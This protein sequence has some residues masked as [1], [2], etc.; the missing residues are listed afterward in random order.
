MNKEQLQQSIDQITEAI[1]LINTCGG[2][3]YLKAHQTTQ[4][5]V[6]QRQLMQKQLD[7][8]YIISVDGEEVTR[9][10]GRFQAIKEGKRISRTN[11]AVVATMEKW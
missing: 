11:S 10:V 3:D 4:L 7:E 2:Y 9:V 8:T 1:A 6:E 5:M